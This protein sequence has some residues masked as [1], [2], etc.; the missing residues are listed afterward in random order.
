V[1]ALEGNFNPSK[2]DIE[3][4][5]LRGENITDARVS[6]NR[7][8]GGGGKDLCVCVINLFKNQSGYPQAL[9]GKMNR[10]ASVAAMQEAAF[11]YGPAIDSPWT[12]TEV[13]KR[14][15]LTLHKYPFRC[16]RV[17]V[18]VCVCVDCSAIGYSRK[19]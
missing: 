19:N 2:P 14:Y 10:P 3:R 17:C 15:N 18:C 4:R 7:G 6:R 9:S 16:V 5:R 8:G 1:S 12:D 11:Q 13:V